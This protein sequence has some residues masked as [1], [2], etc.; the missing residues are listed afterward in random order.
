MT[1][2]AEMFSELINVLK[3]IARTLSCISSIGVIGLIL[4]F[5]GWSKQ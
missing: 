2:D 3:E 4:Y 1:I 5:L